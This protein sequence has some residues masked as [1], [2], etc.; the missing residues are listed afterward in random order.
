MVRKFCWLLFLVPA[1]LSQ[2]CGSGEKLSPVTGSVT[3]GTKPAAGAIVMF[4]PETP[5]LK[6]QP[7]TATAKA[8]GTFEMSTGVSGGVRPGKYI[9]TVVWPD[10]NVKITDAQRM[11]GA[12][13]SDAPDLL[14]GRFATREKS[15][16]K[17]EIKSGENKLEPIVLN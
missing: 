6:A 12:T 13:A 8:D 17:I 2:G 10:P 14:K 5:D 16:I 3:V 7:S 1:M 4:I 11:M 9:V 15:T